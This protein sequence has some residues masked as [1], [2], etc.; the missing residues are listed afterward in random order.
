MVVGVVG[1]IWLGSVVTVE[2][3]SRVED[4]V[5]PMDSLACYQDVALL[6][7]V[8]RG[9][10]AATSNVSLP[11]FCAANDQR[12]GSEVYTNMSQKHFLLCHCL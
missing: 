8:V 1:V 7:F 2:D 10:R 6:N 12:N 3:I 9:R 11:E 5:L 4:P